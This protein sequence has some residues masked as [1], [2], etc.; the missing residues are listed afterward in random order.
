MKSNNNMMKLVLIALVLCMS[1]AFAGAASVAEESTT[2]TTAATATDVTL[3]PSAEWG[4]EAHVY[5]FT[6]EAPM[7]QYNQAPELAQM[8][9]EG[10]IPPLRSRLPELPPIAVPYTQIGTYGG[11]LRTI[12]TDVTDFSR[13]EWN[14]A[15]HLNL[16]TVPQPLEVYANIA[17]SFEIA[18]DLM[19]VTFRLRK[20]IKWS[21]GTPLTTEDFRFAYEDILLYSEDPDVP[22]T[23]VAPGSMIIDGEVVELTV[24]DDWTMRYSWTTPVAEYTTN[25]F[26]ASN[27]DPVPA[28]YLKQ[29]H[30]AYTKSSDMEPSEMML[31]LK[32][33]NVISNPDRPTIAAW[34][35]EDVKTGEYL[36]LTRNPYYWKVDPAGNQLPYLDKIHITYIKS[37]N[38]AL[39]NLTAGEMDFET[40]KISYSGGPILYQSQSSGDYTLVPGFKRPLFVTVWVQQ[41]WIA[42]ALRGETD[43]P[44]DRKLAELLKNPKF[45]E[46]LV[47]GVDTEEITRAFVGAEMASFLGEEF[48]QLPYLSRTA[49]VGTF[50]HPEVQELWDW[51]AEYQRFDIAKAN[52]MLD[53]LGLR[54]GGDGFRQYPDGGRMELTIGIW[55]GKQQWFE[56]ISMQGQRWERDLKIK[57]F[58]NMGNRATH[59]Q[60]WLLNSGLPMLG[61]NAR[62]YD[63]VSGV[64]WPLSSLFHVHGGYPI[65]NWLVSDGAQGVEPYPEQKEV[66][67][68][69]KEIGRM[70]AQ[71]LDQDA[72]LAYAIEATELV[73]QNQ[74]TGQIVLGAQKA[75]PWYLHNRIKNYPGG[76]T[77]DHSETHLETWFI[78]E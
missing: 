9:R 30:P 48:P 15:E 62:V 75:A 55:D 25:V 41:A 57:T 74:T 17:E 27:T 1:A 76:A 64:P 63:W 16:F 71:T 70:S 14:I 37:P 44:E 58:V 22:L 4:G 36:T 28:H 19:S 33:M 38:V 56:M 7:A 32:N 2:G 53:E 77:T 3:P 34:I 42:R 51:L 67:L 59:V 24:I 73:V 20:G 49:G 12:E 40:G 50:D 23:K 8:E 68:K 47:H 78:D 65:L 54:V 13:Q 26:A 69:I 31:E 61:G 43:N 18:A 35:V 52:A 21:D 66:L 29:F 5:M 39:L 46:A 6:P 72:R 45:I 11:T 60:P 10:K